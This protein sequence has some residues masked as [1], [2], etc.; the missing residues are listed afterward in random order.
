MKLVEQA[1][2]FLVAS[3][4]AVCIV[5]C[6]TVPP[7]SPH[8]SHMLGNKRILVEKLMRA[9]NDD[10]TRREASDQRRMLERDAQYAS[11]EEIGA[12]LAPANAAV[13]ERLIV[14]LEHDFTEGELERLIEIYSDP[15]FVKYSEI[16]PRYQE[17][18]ADWRQDDLRS[19]PKERERLL[20]LLRLDNQKPK[21]LFEEK[22][23]PKKVPQ[24]VD[25]Q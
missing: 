19:H 11:G 4:F 22:S 10:I 21:I 7:S 17:K 15:V 8:S 12:A 25:V 6:G 14:A 20:D 13:R 24:S 5:S 2:L 16:Y 9:C 18:L 1:C 3:V 23:R